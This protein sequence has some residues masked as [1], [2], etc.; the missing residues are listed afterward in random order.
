MS[1]TSRVDL[2][3]AKRAAVA[4]LFGLGLI[5]HARN[6]VD[7]FTPSGSLLSDKPLLAVDNAMHLYYASLG[8]ELIARSGQPY[9]YDPTDMAGHPKTPIFDPGIVALER[10]VATLSFWPPALVY[11][12]W[13]LTSIMAA[14]LCPLLALW[15]LGLRGLGWLF[16]WAAILC[17]YWWGQGAVFTVG[18]M[19]AWVLAASLAFLLMGATVRLIERWSRQEERQTLRSWLLPA[20]VGVLMVMVPW[21]HPFGPIPVLICAGLLLTRTPRP[22]HLAL[23][24]VLVAGATSLAVNVGWMISTWSHRG[25]ATPLAEM[26]GG[27][28]SPL[29]LLSIAREEI[30]ESTTPLK[31]INR[32]A[33]TAFHLWIAGA[34]LAG[35]LLLRR[36][37]DYRFIPLMVPFVVFGFLT[38]FSRDIDSLQ[39][40]QPW[41][42]RFLWL[43]LAAALGA[44][45]LTH[46]LTRRGW[47]R[48]AALGSGAFA[49]VY[50]V[51]FA[52]RPDMPRMQIGFDPVHQSWVDTINSL[53]NQRARIL[54]ED[55]HGYRGIATASFQNA[56]NA[57]WV[58]GPYEA[59]YITYHRVAFQEGKLVGRPVADYSEAELTAFF[60]RYNIRWIMAW[61]RPAKDSLD[62]RPSLKKVREIEGVA[63]YEL[64]SPVDSF[65]ERGSGEVTAELDALRLRR[66]VPD[67]GSVVLRFHYYEH[68]MVKGARALRPHPVPG[69]PVP[70]IEVLDPGTDV[71]IHSEHT[72]HVR[73]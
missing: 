60:R 8:A 14:A 67:G 23:P 20:L 47:V 27:A 22:L 29:T 58:G 65:F 55:G 13:T 9:G 41:R 5:L 45:L 62:R 30:A 32:V 11:K 69:D 50:F 26:F 63:F 57:L 36:R 35:L 24:F 56:T 7:L 25:I 6:C 38:F 70:F 37:R 61:S 2:D 46:A 51:A 64:V 54:I 68:L 43:N 72:A 18:G 53:T 33:N 39:N 44:I 49:C 59:A 71:L 1:R 73:N 16:G 31:T 17:V 42:L 12:L 40:L 66:V 10:I 3:G 19:N 15:F 34:G 4:I 48:L 21:I 28:E 52:F